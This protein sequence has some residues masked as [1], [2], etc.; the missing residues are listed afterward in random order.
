VR[1]FD[2]RSDTRVPILKTVG[3]EIVSGHET[4]DWPDSLDALAAVPESPHTLEN[5]DASEIRVISVELK[6]HGARLEATV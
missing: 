6:V 5:V 4:W 2:V 3:S 1:K